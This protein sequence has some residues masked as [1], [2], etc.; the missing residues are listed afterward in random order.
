MVGGDSWNTDYAPWIT[1]S[2]P[3]DNATKDFAAFDWNH[4]GG[5]FMDGH[6]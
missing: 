6:E 2:D 3:T 5:W 4:S 1:D